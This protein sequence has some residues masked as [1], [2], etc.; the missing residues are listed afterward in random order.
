MNSFYTLYT[1]LINLNNIENKKHIQI[2]F[3]N[4]KT[5]LTLQR[6]KSKRVV[7]SVG[8]EHLPYKQ[9]VT[10]SNPVLPTKS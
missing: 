1:I 5:L 6:F 4:K 3:E 8:S 7:S 10:G 9:R 2:Y